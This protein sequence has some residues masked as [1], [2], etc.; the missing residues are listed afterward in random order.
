MSLLALRAQGALESR[1]QRDQHE[2]AERRVG[3]AGL[4]AEQKR[5]VP[6]P[7]VERG[8]RAKL[9]LSPQRS[10]RMRQQRRSAQN[11]SAAQATAF[12][13][14]VKIVTIFAFDISPDQGGIR[15]DLAGIVGKRRLPLG[16]T[17][18]AAPVLDEGN[19]GHFQRDHRLHH[20]GAAVRPAEK[21]PET[22]E[23]DDRIASGDAVRF[24]QAFPL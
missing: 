15:D 21:R 8:P 22:V 3:A 10:Q 12:C 23:R 20:E 13:S 6:D 16:R 2:C 14:G 19:A 4:F 17:K 7:P 11:F 5:L 1:T 18:Q 9:A 24:A